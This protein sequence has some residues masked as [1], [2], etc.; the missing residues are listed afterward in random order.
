[1]ADSVCFLD[2]YFAASI[3][4]SPRVKDLRVELIM[5]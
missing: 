1:M 2:A 3:V 4:E 5:A